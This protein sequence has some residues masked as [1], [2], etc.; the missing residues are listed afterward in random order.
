MNMSFDD[1]DKFAGRIL[2]M[3]SHI[4][5]NKLPYKMSIQNDT[6]HIQVIRCYFDYQILKK[7]NELG[8]KIIEIQNLPDM[9]L[10]VSV[11]EDE[12]V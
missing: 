9:G 11:K 2:N 8:L 4:Q 10:I 5:D 6:I 3:Y 1:D 12:S 7:I